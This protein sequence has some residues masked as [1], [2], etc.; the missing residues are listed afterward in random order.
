MVD[1]FSSNEKHLVQSNFKNLIIDKLQ[2][3]LESSIKFYSQLYFKG[4]EYRRGYYLSI[5]NEEIMFYLIHEIVIVERKQLLFFCQHL[6]NVKYDDHII[7]YELDP[8]NLGSFALLTTEQVIGPPIHLIRTAKGKH[9]L[10][11]KEYY[12]CI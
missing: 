1:T 12:R 8:T 9:I 5:L 4:V 6:K 3:V 7:V 10:R 2:N 11:P